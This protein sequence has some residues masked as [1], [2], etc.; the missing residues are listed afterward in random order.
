[1]ATMRESQIAQT[2][3]IKDGQAAQTEAIYNRLS[4]CPV[5][6]T[7]VY[8]RTPIFSCNNNGGCGCNGNAFAYT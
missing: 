2:A 6:S 7:P 5:P 8:G 4:Q 3:A 1:M